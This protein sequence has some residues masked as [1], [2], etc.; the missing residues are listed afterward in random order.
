M[1]RKNLIEVN[2]LILPNNNYCNIYVY[3]GS[4]TLVG[5]LIGRPSSNVIHFFPPPLHIQARYV[6]L[7]TN[8]I[9]HFSSLL[10]KL[11]ATWR[12]HYCSFSIRIHQPRLSC[13]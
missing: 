5:S 4:P 12:L 7:K 10:F 13:A 2:V 1:S 11:P 6:L 8:C 3:V 9:I